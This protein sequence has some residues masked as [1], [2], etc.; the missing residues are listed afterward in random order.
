M[1]WLIF[2]KDT[3]RITGLQNYTPESEYNL[4]V[5]ED[6]YVDFM[7]NP[8]KKNKIVVKYDLSKKEYVLSCFSKKSTIHT[9]LKM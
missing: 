6:A 4:E 7:T 9:I 1:Y 8:D 3:S 2:D 5:S